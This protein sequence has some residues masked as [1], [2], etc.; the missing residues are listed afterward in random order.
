MTTF[1]YSLL[2]YASR[3]MNAEELHTAR[4]LAA[5]ADGGDDG[6]REELKRMVRHVAVDSGGR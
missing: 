5:A 3:L 6:A 2:R 1:E 4:R